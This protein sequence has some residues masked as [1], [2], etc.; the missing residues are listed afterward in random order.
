MIKSERNNSWSSEVEDNSSPD[1]F[2][3]IKARRVKKACSLDTS[4]SDARCL[5]KRV[6]GTDKALPP[7]SKYKKKW[8]TSPSTSRRYL[9]VGSVIVRI[10]KSYYDCASDFG[11]IM[12][13]LCLSFITYTIDFKVKDKRIAC[14]VNALKECSTKRKREEKT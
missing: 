7:T 1:Q 9:C 5:L 14:K 12:R 8:S 13:S 11:K 4:I 10:G 6:Q 2:G 3:A